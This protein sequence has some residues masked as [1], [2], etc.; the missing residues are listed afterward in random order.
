MKKMRILALTLALFTM[1]T[2]VSAA[3]MGMNTHWGQGFSASS[4]L[5]MLEELEVEYI[6]DGQD[7]GAVERTPG[8][9]IT[10]GA[11]D[12]INVAHAAGKKVIWVLGFGNAIYDGCNGTNSS[13]H[14][15]NKHNV[16]N[17]VMP[18]G[19]TYLAGWENY[20]KFVANRYKGKID[21][22]EVWNEPWTYRFNDGIK[23]TA[24]TYVE[25]VRVTKAALASVGSDAK[26]MAGAVT[27]E[28][29]FRWGLTT[30]DYF[31]AMLNAGV[32]EYADIISVHLYTQKYA[33]S[34]NHKCTYTQAQKTPEIAY[35]DWLNYYEGMLDAKGYTGQLWLTEAGWY[36]GATSNAVTKEMQAA[37]TIRQKVIWDAYLKDNNRT[38]EYIHYQL[39]DN[40]TTSADAQRNNLFGLVTFDGVK[41]P[42]YWAAKAYNTL[43]GDMEFASLSTSPTQVY[44]ATYTKANG[45]AAN[46]IWKP[47]GT[48]SQTL[49][50][51]KEITNIYDYQGN[52][53]DSARLAEG[54]VAVTVG[55]NPIFVKGVSDGSKINGSAL[56][57][58]DAATGQM[59]VSG[60]MTG[61]QDGENASVILYNKLAKTDAMDASYIAYLGQTALQAGGFT[62]SFQIPA[63]HNGAYTL[64]LGATNS[65]TP[66]MQTLD[67]YGNQGCVAEL[68][69][70]DL[71]A[72]SATVAIRNYGVAP[73]EPV[74]FL[75]QYDKDGNLL[76][77]SMDSKTVSAKA[78]DS[79]G[80][81][82][83]TATGTKHT[84][85]KT[86]RAFV[87]DGI[88]S[89]QPIS[90]PIILQ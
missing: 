28:Y 57:V 5:P 60:T 85:T 42:A 1:G 3:P 88:S 40:Y 8:N 89:M 29:S 46:V 32:T 79:A 47:D 56:V 51:E 72:M 30:H 18:T 65:L 10:Q 64:A 36:E 82:T 38:G 59:T 50:L 58:Y 4:Y 44:K 12:L 78:G 53:I 16:E 55:P 7:W 43:V 21:V 31:T 11:D 67:I 52:L 66:Q 63:S 15:S 24:G 6:R 86:V 27:N 14:D 33:D 23:G 87:W 68:T 22:F 37:Y 34:E 39:K 49:T 2:G 69:L 20:V 80:T 54:T 73:I 26:V 45:E 41:K 84:K 9:Y 70:S 81:N 62:H 61:Y 13:D 74:L 48:T 77:A 83:L 25:L 76:E 19:T 75:C 71:T 90:K 35:R 17:Y